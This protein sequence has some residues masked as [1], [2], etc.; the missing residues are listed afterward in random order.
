MRRKMKC[1][2]SCDFNEEVCLLIRLK[3]EKTSFQNWK[4]NCSD[5]IDCKFKKL[6]TND[7]VGDNIK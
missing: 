6:L 3:Q 4:V 5:N 2:F 1:D 7:I